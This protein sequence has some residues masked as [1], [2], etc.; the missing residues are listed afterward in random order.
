MSKQDV[1]R[2]DK[3]TEVGIIFACVNLTGDDIFVAF[4]YF[5]VRSL[6]SFF[7]FLI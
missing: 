3:E 7:S 6:S 5:S 2:R 4:S 1:K